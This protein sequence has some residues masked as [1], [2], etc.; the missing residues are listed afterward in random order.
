MFS[1]M[2]VNVDITNMAFL[3]LKGKTVL[4]LVFKLG[5]IRVFCI[6]CQP[7]YSDIVTLTYIYKVLLIHANL[8]DIF[9]QLNVRFTILLNQ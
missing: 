2:Y 7:L 6:L 8:L 1:Y 5:Y 4:L 9:T 3:V